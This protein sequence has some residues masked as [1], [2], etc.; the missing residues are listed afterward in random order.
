ML[1]NTCYSVRLLIKIDVLA[2]AAE[3]LAFG[4]EML[5]WGVVHNDHKCFKTSLILKETRLKKTLVQN[6]ALRKI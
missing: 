2:T 3:G 5:F 6:K 4:G 1:I